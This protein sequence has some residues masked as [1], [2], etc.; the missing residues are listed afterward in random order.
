MPSL[1]KPP[2][3]HGAA[4]PF[5]A[6][7]VVAASGGLTS[8]AF[9][10]RCLTQ[11]DPGADCAVLVAAVPLVTLP[12]AAGLGVIGA[13]MAGWLVR[14]EADAEADPAHTPWETA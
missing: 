11:P 6:V 1:P 9:G 10:I 13:G 5:L 2:A 7:A 4:L 3:V 12:L 14:D 8:L